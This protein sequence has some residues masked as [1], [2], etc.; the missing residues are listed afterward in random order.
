MNAPQVEFRV[1]V[2]H[3]LIDVKAAALE[4]G[5]ELARP[6]LLPAI[7]SATYGLAG[8]VDDVRYQMLKRPI[9][10][11]INEHVV[12]D[13][14]GRR[15]YVNNQLVAKWGRPDDAVFSRAIENSASLGANA[16]ALLDDK[17]GPLWHVDTN[18]LHE[19]TRLIIP[20][21][22]AAF[23][24][25]V[26]GRPLA[27]VPE[28]SQMYIGGDA[29]PELVL[30]LAEK[31][32]AE[33]K[34]SPRGISPAI[35]TVT[36]DGVVTPYRRDGSDRVAYAVQLGHTMLAHQEYGNHREIAQKRLGD[37][38]FVASYSAVE[39]SSACRSCARSDGQNPQSWGTWNV[40]GLAISKTS[41]EGCLQ[42]GRRQRLWFSRGPRPARLPG[43]WLPVA[44]LK[45]GSV[46]ACPV[47][48]RRVVTRDPREFVGFDVIGTP[49]TQSLAGVLAD[50]SLVAARRCRKAC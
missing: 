46:I 6:L 11:F 43:S 36:D 3:V 4:E 49:S 7:R 42:S 41:V 22:L 29:R 15:G 30:R 35:Y 44:H 38:V 47:C 28:R 48:G 14:P 8:P 1:Q 17:H 20:G 26:E 5:L 9:L 33:W 21:F 12:I 27:I 13:E 24:D 19:S 23:R 16:A 31:A 18:D 2:D 32:A 40:G 34:A 50:P 45:V 37:E 10:P 25:R 39:T